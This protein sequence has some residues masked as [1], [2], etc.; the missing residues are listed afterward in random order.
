MA[1]TGTNVETVLQQRLGGWIDEVGLDKTQGS[2]IYRDPIA[3]ALR[4]GGYAVANPV[5]PANTDLDDVST[6]DYDKIFDLA[7]YRLLQ[8]LLQNYEAV[9]LRVGER[10]EKY[11]QLRTRMEKALD[12]KR[13]Q[14]Q[15]DYDFAL[16]IASFEIY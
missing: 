3:W 9:D 5:L 6:A 1:L 14:L 2:S 10:D 4:K 8:N 15:E 16:R 11:D 12:L 7:E 13:K